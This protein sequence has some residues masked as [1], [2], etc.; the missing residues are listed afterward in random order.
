MSLRKPMRGKK[1]ARK[2]RNSA[3][4]TKKINLNPVIRRGGI[5]L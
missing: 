4:K 5:R 2:F 3:V 1:D